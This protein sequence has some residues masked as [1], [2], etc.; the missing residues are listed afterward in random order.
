MTHTYELSIGAES[1][2]LPDTG[3]QP[4]MGRKFCYEIFYVTLP[5]T[6][7][8]IAVVESQGGSFG[9]VEPS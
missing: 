5:G 2:E 9:Q 6:F 1:V 3:T 7:P 4:K 8:G